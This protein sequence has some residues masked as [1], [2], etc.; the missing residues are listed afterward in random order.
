MDFKKNL[1][2]LIFDFE[3]VE[4]YSVPIEWLD[5]LELFKLSQHWELHRNKLETRYFS[6]DVE[7]AIKL[8]EYEKLSDE[9]KQTDAFDRDDNPYDFAQRL[10]SL[11]DVANLGLEFEDGEVLWIALPWSFRNEYE[12]ENEMAVIDKQHRLL[13]FYCSNDEESLAHWKFFNIDR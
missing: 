13:K 2:N 11:H 10:V 12:N 1:K 3:N 4:D 6:D 9:D 7:L 5:E 8:D